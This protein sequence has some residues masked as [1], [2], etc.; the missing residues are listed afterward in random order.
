MNHISRIGMFFMNPMVYKLNKV[1]IHSVHASTYSGITMKTIFMIMMTIV[2]IGAYIVMDH[3]YSNNFIVDMEGYHINFLG[4]AIVAGAFLYFIF[5]PFI[6]FFFVRTSMV[7]GTLYSLLQGFTLA[8]LCFL[9]PTIYLYPSLIALGLTILIVW[10]MLILYRSHVI[11]V[12]QKVASVIS[13]LCFVSMVGSLLL[14]ISGLFPATRGI[15]LF[16]QENAILVITSSLAGIVIAS[17]FLLVDFEVMHHCVEDSLPKKYEWLAAY[18]LS[19][20][21]IQLYLKIFHF[22]IGFC[23]LHK[24]R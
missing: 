23:R 21:V 16:F 6:S 2:G 19:Y 5:A 11:D 9:L 15:W 8:F 20:S 18:A 7:I 13:V 14:F 10:S 3:F 12:T 22:A 1:N 24:E 4:A 17:L